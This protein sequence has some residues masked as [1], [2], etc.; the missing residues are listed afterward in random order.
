MLMTL[1]TEKPGSEGVHQ[2]VATEVDPV[3]R[4]DEDCTDERRGDGFTKA[5]DI[6]PSELLGK[7]PRVQESWEGGVIHV[8]ML[9]VGG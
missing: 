2:A 1:G 8:R 6:S 3:V 7:G 9:E 4:V 5:S